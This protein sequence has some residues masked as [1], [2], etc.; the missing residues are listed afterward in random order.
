MIKMNVP[1]LQVSP[2]VAGHAISRPR[3]HLTRMDLT[4]HHQQQSQL[5]PDQLI[6]LP[7][8]QAGFP[9]S[10]FMYTC[11]LHG[12]GR[13]DFDAGNIHYKGHGKGWAL[14]SRLFWALKR[15]RAKRLP[16]GPKKFL[17]VHLHHSS[18]IKSHKEVTKSRNQG[19]SSYFCLL[20]EGSESV[21]RNYGDLGGPET[22]GSG[23]QMRIRNTGVRRCDCRVV[24][25]A[26]SLLF[27]RT[28]GPI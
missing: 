28:C 25:Q 10:L 20:M 18:K 7:P 14:K 12:A 1:V 26:F 19:F 4:D 2:M 5:Q 15:Q 24:L 23:F 22:Y 3:I 8:E 11:C 27:Y 17:N 16:F 21:Q 13:N 6:Q 9:Q